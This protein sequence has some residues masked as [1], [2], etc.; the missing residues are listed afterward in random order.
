[1]YRWT[2][3]VR[4]KEKIL[5]MDDG[6]VDLAMPDRK[7]N[8]KSISLRVAALEASR[9]STPVSDTSDRRGVSYTVDVEAFGS[10]TGAL[11]FCTVL[12]QGVGRV[13]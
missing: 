4:S 11:D 8:T 13:P 1:M 9:F 2:S 10:P 6:Q 5:F 7:A 3:P 12:F